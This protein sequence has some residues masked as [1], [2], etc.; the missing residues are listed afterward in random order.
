MP[1]VEGLNDWQRQVAINT[2]VFLRTY[3]ALEG[4][5]GFEKWPAFLIVENVE[6][7]SDDQALT[8][9]GCFAEQEWDEPEDWP[10]SIVLVLK[11]GSFLHRDLHKFVRCVIS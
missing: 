2:H 11:E 3:A 4:I 6:T 10:K 7:L 9:R 1:N 8:L 5:L